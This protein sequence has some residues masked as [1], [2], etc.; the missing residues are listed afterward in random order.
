MSLHFTSHVGL[1]I[2]TSY[3]LRPTELVIRV[4]GN[5]SCLP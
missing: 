2:L 5:H 3:E 1:I 4:S